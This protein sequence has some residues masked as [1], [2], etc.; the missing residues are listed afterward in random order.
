MYM[1]FCLVPETHLEIV[2]NAIFETGAGQIGDYKYCAWQTLGQGQF[3]PLTGSNAFIG[4]INQLEKVA[5]YKIEIA[6]TK[7]QLKPAV[8]ALKQA[9]P[10]ETPAYHIIQCETIE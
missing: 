4:E 6:C 1:L 5:E 9:H 2:K 7:A 10:Y 3:M 8:H